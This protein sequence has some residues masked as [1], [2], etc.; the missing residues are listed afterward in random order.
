MTHE[1]TVPCNCEDIEHCVMERYVSDV[2]IAFDEIER[3]SKA[4][5]AFT[6]ARPMPMTLVV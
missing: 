3:F 6:G 1:V 5:E 2:R 4:V